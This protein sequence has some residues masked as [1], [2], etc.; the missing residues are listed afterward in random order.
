MG[1]QLPDELVEVMDL[2][3][4]QWPQIDEDDVRDSAK[5]YRKLAEGLRD[6]IADGNRACSHIVAGKSKGKTVDAIDRRWGKLTTKDITQFAKGLDDLGDALDDCAVLIEGCKAVCVAE[7][8]ATAATATAGIVGM[9][10]TAGLSALL[11]AAAVTA[12]RIAVQEAID[13]AID[14]IGDIVTEKIENRILAKIEDVFTDRL[15]SADDEDLNG[16]AR[17]G[18][19]LASDLLIEFD[20]FD[21]AHGGYQETRDN[22]DKKKGSFKG[23]GGKRRG[24]MKKDGRFHK[25]A[26]VM[27]KA[28]D[29]V[30]KKTDAFSDTLEDH[31]GKLK[32][33][34][35]D[36]KE[37][38]EARKRD[39]DR[40]KVDDE[41][42][43]P[44]YLLNTDGSVVQLHTDGST[45]TRVSGNESGLR[46]ILE[47]NGTAWRPRSPEANP[48]PISDGG[49]SADRVKSRRL[50]KGE[51]SDL[52]YATQL[53]RYS[54]GDYKGGNYAAARYIGDDGE[55]VILVGHSKG[56]HSERTIGYP[57]LRHG[58]EDNIQALYTEREPCQ[59]PPSWCDQWVAKYFDKDLEVTHSVSY[60]QNAKDE[61][62]NP[63]SKYKIDAEHREYRRNLEEWHKKHGLNRGMMT[64]GDAR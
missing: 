52:A 32:K 51:T 5:D 42:D 25:L 31:G 55:E 36:H 33:S 54:K 15:T 39:F 2:I 12:C 1:K 37:N 16:Y 62:G 46:E 64:E 61:N 4:I 53:A 44:M 56:V 21:R 38:D 17:G 14:Q 29:A 48:Y 40:C 6:A 43:V 35:K 7:L 9:F 13:Y 41:G 20:E 23:D 8:T 11:S 34:R 49:P 10:F 24:S 30:E 27:D 47:S 63:I 50:G 28:E 45:P 59:N 60:D 19:D 3:G 58:R 18:A 57:V 22:F 26:V